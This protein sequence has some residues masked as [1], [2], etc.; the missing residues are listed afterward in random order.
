MQDRDVPSQCSRSFGTTR[1]GQREARG[2]TRQPRRDKPY[3]VVL[4]APIVTAHVVNSL[5][6]QPRTVML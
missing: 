5:G 2:Q 6:Y 4:A 3:L 1:L